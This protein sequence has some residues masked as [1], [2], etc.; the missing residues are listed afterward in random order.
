MT[1][2]WEGKEDVKVGGKEHPRSKGQ[3]GAYPTHGGQSGC[4]PR[5][6]SYTGGSG[7]CRGPEDINKEGND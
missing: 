6:A 5:G 1:G 7:T 2:R 3:E 4:T